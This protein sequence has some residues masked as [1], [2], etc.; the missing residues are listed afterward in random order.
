ME[1][2][3]PAWSDWLQ[4]RLAEILSRELLIALADGGRTKRIR[5]TA[6]ATLRAVPD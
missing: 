6:A 3:L 4:L 2:D 5:R 1:A